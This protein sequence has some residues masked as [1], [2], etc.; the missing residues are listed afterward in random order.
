MIYHIHFNAIKTSHL[1]K[2]PDWYAGYISKGAHVPENLKGL[3]REHLNVEFNQRQLVAKFMRGSS[4][5]SFVFVITGLQMEEFTKF[6]KEEN[7]EEL[8]VFRSKQITNYVHPYAGRNLTLVVFASKKHAWR[9]MY[10]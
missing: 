7:L 8:E 9:D 10:N 5:N 2:I 3:K 1:T 6:I 4:D